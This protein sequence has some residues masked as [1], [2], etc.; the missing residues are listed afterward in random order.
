M[1]LNRSHHKHLTIFI[2]LQNAF[3]SG[4]TKVDL[5]RNGH[6]CVT[7]GSGLDQTIQKMVF[8]SFFQALVMF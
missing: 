5:T 7:L 1:A 4:T 3:A 6:Y 8:N 2:T